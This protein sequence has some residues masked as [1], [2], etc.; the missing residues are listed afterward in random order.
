MSLTDICHHS[1][2]IFGPKEDEALDVEATD[3]A[4]K[5]LAFTINADKGKNS[6][7]SAEEVALGFVRVA[8][9][10]M[11]RPVRS[12]TEARGYETGLHHLVMF[13]GAGGQV[14]CAIAT[15][16]GIKRTLLVFG[17]C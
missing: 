17:K 7:L 13:G 16:L 10:S 8:V 14:A 5:D 2:K 9:E 4:F 6:S 15:S 11:C 3:A 12:L 1:P